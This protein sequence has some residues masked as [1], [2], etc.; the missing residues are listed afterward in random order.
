[1]AFDE[2]RQRLEVEDQRDRFPI[3]DPAT[4]LSFENR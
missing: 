4:G 3:R 2:E 1:M